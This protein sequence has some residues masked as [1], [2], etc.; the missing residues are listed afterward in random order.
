MNAEGNAK[1][2]TVSRFVKRMLA[3]PLH[4]AH[5]LL[6]KAS[7]YRRSARLAESATALAI[8]RQTLRRIR[9]ELAAQL[10][11]DASLPQETASTLPIPAEEQSLVRAIAAETERMNRNNVTRTQAYYELYSR[12]PELHWAL[13]AHMVSRN[14]GW[15]MTDLRGELLPRLLT[16]DRQRKSFAF[17]ERANSFIFHDAYPQLLLYEA[18]KSRGKSL[19]HLLPSFR[20]SAFMR[21]IW[22]AFWRDRCSELLTASLIINEQHYIE[23]RVVR[24]EP[25]ASMLNSIPYR[26]QTWLQL[27]VLALP[28]VSSLPH[29]RLAGR[30]LEH[31]ANLQERIGIGIQLYAI[32]FGV[33]DIREGVLKFASSTPHTGSRA[34]YWPQL[35]APERPS[36]PEKPYVEKLKGCSLLPGAARLCSPKLADAWPDTPFDPPPRYDWFDSLTV[37]EYYD[38]LTVPHAFEITNEACF[39][40]NKIELAVLTDQLL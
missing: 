37:M 24:S 5:Y 29:P 14:G 7:N 16:D 10:R 11:R 18:S 20:V 13:L 2:A 19:F 6:G 28:Y 27:N 39:A 8:P 1:A 36:S 17:L 25:F 4:A 34:D 35:F 38:D 12:H 31:F 22:D 40:L 26:A 21:P 3:I 9:H 30:V 23:N 15:N 33:P 32:L